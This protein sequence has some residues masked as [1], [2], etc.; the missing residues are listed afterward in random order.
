M[1]ILNNANMRYAGGAVP[2]GSSN[3]FSSH[4]ALQFAASDHQHQHLA[5]GRHRRHRVSH[6]GRYGLVPRRRLGARSPDPPGHRLAE[7]LE[8]HLADVGEQRICRA[9]HGDELPDQSDVAG[10]SINYTFFE[11]LPIIVL[12]QLVVG[13][14]FIENS[15]GQTDWVTGPALHPAR[16][17]DGVQSRQR[18]RRP[19][20]RLEPQRRIAGLHQRERPAGRL[21]PGRSARATTSTS[22]PRTRKSCSPRSTTTRRRPPPRSSRCRST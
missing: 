8:R 6:R 4:H 20:P 9:D 19:E 18:T 1:S 13:Q 22:R 5:L 10:G 3:F 12:A 17:A 15:G 16:R 14:E 2:Q 7:Q 11:P 21:H